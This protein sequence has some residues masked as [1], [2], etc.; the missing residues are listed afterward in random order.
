[1]TLVL[2]IILLAGTWFLHFTRLFTTVVAFADIVF[3]KRILASTV[4]RFNTTIYVLGLDLS[5]AFDTDSK[6]H[7][8]AWCHVAREN[9][10][11]GWFTTG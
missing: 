1:M 11:R 3:C 2:N 8:A 4:E 10:R 6:P 9:W 7:K 5:K